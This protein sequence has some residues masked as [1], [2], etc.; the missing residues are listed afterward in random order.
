ME[1]NPKQIINSFYLEAAFHSPKEL[2]KYMAK[3]IKDSK[4]KFD[5]IAVRGVSGLMIGPILTYVLNKHLLII[6]KRGEKSHSLYRVEG[7]VNAR[8]V[9]IVDDFVATGD[10]VDDIIE[11]I[12]IYVNKGDDRPKDAPPVEFVGIA[13]YRNHERTYTKSFRLNGLQTIKLP[14]WGLALPSGR[15]F[16]MEMIKPE[17]QNLEM[18]Q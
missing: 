4:L 11:N 17:I 5:T 12:N 7:N 10:T 1:R 6:R 13:C 16:P 14:I 2:I 9:L 15:D 8:R 3:V 18:N